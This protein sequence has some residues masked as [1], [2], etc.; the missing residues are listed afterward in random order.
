MIVAAGVHPRK[1]S[2]PGI[3]HPMVVSY[4][5]AILAPEKI[6]KRVALIGAGG[7]GFD[8]AEL[9]VHDPAHKSTALDLPAWLA[10]WGIEDP[11]EVRAGLSTP[12]KQ[13]PMREVFLCQRSV[14]KLGENL[15]KTT[16]WIHRTTL[17]HRDV[18]M[19][20]GV[21][22]DKID[23]E[24]LHVHLGKEAVTLAVDN[25]VVCA[26]QTPNR[27]LVDA[28]LQAGQI[29]HVVG[30]ADE[31]RELDAKRAIAQAARLAAHL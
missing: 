21:T 24:G 3:D 19:L 10:E 2:L 11:N 23:D 7:I 1:L 26:G 27:D 13:P 17:K 29:V 31:A 20:A 6:G 30:G 16:G 5:D 18:K 14:G 4:V 8:V 28:L 9:L 25:V 15:G 22:Y 12:T